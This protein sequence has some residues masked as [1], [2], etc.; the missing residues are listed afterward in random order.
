[1]APH[2]N[3]KW[4]TF[5]KVGIVQVPLDFVQCTSHTSILFPQAKHAGSHLL[6]KGQW[7]VCSETLKMIKMNGQKES[8]KALPWM[9]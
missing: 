9:S 7:K 8:Q 4:H 6:S 3:Y 2:T 1:M 5:V